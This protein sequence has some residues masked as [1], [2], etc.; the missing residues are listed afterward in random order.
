[1][2]YL[3]IK[4]I[5]NSPKSELIEVITDGEGEKT[6]K[7]RIKAPAEKGKANKELI[8]FL[9]KQYSLPKENISIISGKTERIKLIKIIGLNST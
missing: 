7:I 1:M 8:K 9:S 6:H 3:R 4:V 5:P 2:L